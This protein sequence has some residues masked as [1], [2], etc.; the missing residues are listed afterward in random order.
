MQNTVLLLGAPRSG[1]TWLGKIFDSAPDVIYRHEPDSVIH[2]PR[3]PQW[4][5]AADAEGSREVAQS[6][7]LKLAQTR[8]IKTNGVMPVFRKSYH[9]R[10]GYW[11]RVMCIFTLKMAE[12]VGPTQGWAEKR[13]IPD[14]VNADHDAETVLVIKSVIGL[15]RAYLFSRIL[16]NGKIVV[17]IRHPCGYV[18][19]QLR[20][21]R[22][23]MMSGKVAIQALSETEQAR[24][25]GL[26]YA[27]LKAMDLVEQLAWHW[28]IS[29]EK[30]MEETRGQSNVKLISYEQLCADPLHVSRKLFDFCRIRWTEQTESFVA[31]STKG[32]K[33]AGYFELR[34]ATAQAANKWQN[35]LAAKDIKRIQR[36]T[37]STLPGSLYF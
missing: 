37:A 22:V 31:Y 9:G 23:G 2:D 14:F 24:S 21:R 4:V 11:L 13:C 17:I 19:S 15:G 8:N 27:A 16:E 28:V 5:V 34:R 36:I 33:D 12:Q 18:A 1:T 35:E 7:L 25:K 30:T 10:L 26:T 29:N 20:G 3:L 6:Y 32:Y